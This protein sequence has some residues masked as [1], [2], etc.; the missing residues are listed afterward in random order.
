MVELELPVQVLQIRQ[1]ES[2]K[3]GVCGGVHE[4]AYRSRPVTQRIVAL[5]VEGN[6]HGKWGRVPSLKRRRHV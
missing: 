2:R 3:T 6:E 5:D 1:R 4:I